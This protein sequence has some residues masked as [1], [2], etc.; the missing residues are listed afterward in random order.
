MTDISD[1]E[2]RRQ[3]ETYS[4]VLAGLFEAAGYEPVEPPILQPADVFLDRSG[5]DIRRRLYVFTDPA[6]EELCLRPDLTIP[7]CRLYLERGL[8]GLARLCYTGSAFRFQP[9]RSAKPA[10][11][12]QAGAEL[13][14]AEDREA[15]DAEMF[16]LAVRGLN[17]T[18][19]TDFDIALGDLGL[20]GALVD[21]LNIPPAWRGRLKRHFWRPDYFRELLARL[22][23]DGRMADVKPDRDGLFMALASLDRDAA[24]ALIDDV[25]KL[26]GIDQ[27]GGRSIEE[28]ADRFLEQATDAESVAL[29]AEVTS[30]IESFI[31]MDWAADRAVDEIRGLTSAAG[32]TI[33]PQLAVLDRR[34]DLI[35]KSGV[36]LAKTCFSPGFGR[37][38]EYYTGFV[39]EL[40]RPELGEASVIAGGGR[41]DGLLESLGAPSAVPA[42]GCA[43]TLERLALAAGLKERAA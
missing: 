2:Q 18:G 38:M 10:E 19:V 3:R 39:F 20:F 8:T 21:V 16:E 6:G 29:S 17:E 41:Y 1:R 26:A 37:K 33:E 36:D 9:Q 28:I 42:V 34:L 5:E 43:T 15:A 32:V 35:G 27:V 25:L 14:G 12:A 24:R 11:F 31:G 4:A 30:L 40:S 23:S 7:T 22:V 13:I